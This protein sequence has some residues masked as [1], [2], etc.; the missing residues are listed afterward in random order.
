MARDSVRLAVSSRGNPLSLLFRSL[1]LSL[2]FPLFLEITSAS[3]GNRLFV[4]VFIKLRGREGNS[5]A[6]G[7]DLVDRSQSI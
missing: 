6:R 3:R 7:I 5:T 4:T 1:G 2:S